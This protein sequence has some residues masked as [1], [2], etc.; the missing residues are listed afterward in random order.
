[1]CI[2]QK[3]S[4]LLLL[5]AA[6]MAAQEYRPFIEEGKTWICCDFEYENRMLRDSTYHY[7][8]FKIVGDSTINDTKYSKLLNIGVLRHRF[9][10]ERGYYEYFFTY[11]TLYAGALRESERQ[12]WFWRN[13]DTEERLLYDFNMH[14]GDEYEVSTIQGSP[15]KICVETDNQLHLYEDIENAY[16]GYPRRCWYFSIEGGRKYN[17]EQYFMSPCIIEGLGCVV[18]PFYTEY[19]PEYNG[20]DEFLGLH[21]CFPSFDYIENDNPEEC[22]Y[23]T[24]VIRGPIINKI[25]MNTPSSKMD[26]SMLHDLQGRRLKAE[27][28]HGVFINNCRKDMK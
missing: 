1:M 19:W 4:I 18:H 25:E 17:S 27:P 12:V 22:Y 8:C 15:Y 16:I 10:G 2:L 26:A 5:Y 14:V 6:N 3:Y 24:I 28:Q 9:I 11:D 23:N 20:N 13:G 21:F 7:E